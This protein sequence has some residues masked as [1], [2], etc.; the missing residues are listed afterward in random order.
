MDSTVFSL[1]YRSLAR[2]DSGN[3]QTRQFG[4]TSPSSQESFMELTEA[5]RIY[6]EAVLDAENAGRD[7]NDMSIEGEHQKKHRFDRVSPAFDAI[8]LQKE[9]Q[10]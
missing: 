9:R 8:F 5:K 7:S 10:M 6:G 3:I 2:S 4:L 1:H